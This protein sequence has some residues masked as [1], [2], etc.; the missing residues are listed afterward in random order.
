MRQHLHRIETRS[1]LQI[2]CEEK[3][4]QRAAVNWVQGEE[5]DKYII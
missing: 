5:K 1:E 2:Y 4:R 3:R